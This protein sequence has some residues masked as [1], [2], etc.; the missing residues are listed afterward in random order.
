MVLRA[1]SPTLSIMFAL[2]YSQSAFS[3]CFLFRYALVQ[4]QKDSLLSWKKRKTCSA[5]SCAH[6]SL[7]WAETER[8]FVTVR[9]SWSFNEISVPTYIK[10]E[11]N[12]GW[13]NDS[14]GWVS[15]YTRQCQNDD[16]LRTIGDQRFSNQCFLQDDDITTSQTDMSSGYPQPPL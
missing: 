10:W 12:D 2:A 3:S 11:F 16:H 7:D 8:Y 4:G 13:V 14:N 5:Q 15:K 1:L 9:R 6:L